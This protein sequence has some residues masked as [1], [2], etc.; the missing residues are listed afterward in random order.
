MEREE[1]DSCYMGMMKHDRTSFANM[2]KDVVMKEYPKSRYF[3]GRELNDTI[4]GI[5]DTLD[6]TADSISKH[7]SDSM[8]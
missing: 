3:R 2:P 1:L 6:N 7:Q 4:S 5:D 8:Y